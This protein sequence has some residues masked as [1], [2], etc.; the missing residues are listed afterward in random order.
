MSK[1]QIFRIWQWLT[2]NEANDECLDDQYF[3]I[4]NIIVQKFFLSP[5]MKL[6][7]SKICDKCITF[8]NLLSTNFINGNRNILLLIKRSQMLN[9]LLYFSLFLIKKDTLPFSRIKKN[10]CSFVVFVMPPYLTDKNHINHK[11]N[12]LSDF[13]FQFFF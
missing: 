9:Y 3:S 10:L 6:Y 5:P 13:N 7:K 2:I 1:L 8:P 12:N 4:H 11:I